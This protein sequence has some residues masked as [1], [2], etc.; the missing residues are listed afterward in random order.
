MG[1][2]HN[3]IRMYW[4]GSAEVHPGTETVVLAAAA[5]V[6]TV[7]AAARAAAKVG[8]VEVRIS[9]QAGRLFVHQMV[10][11]MEAV[12]STEIPSLT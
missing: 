3:K 1:H 2:L 9:H 7:A 10:C 5:P 12:R 6:D 8:E 4:E 11:T